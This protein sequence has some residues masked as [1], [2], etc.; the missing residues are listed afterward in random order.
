M[1]NELIHMG[2][3]KGKKWERMFEESRRFYSPEG[4]SPTIPTNA[5]GHHEVKIGELSPRLVGGVG[6]K[7][8]NNGTQYYQQDRIYSSD[9]V[10]MA[11][12]AQI[13]GGSYMYAVEEEIEVFEK[14][15]I[16]ASRGRDPENPSCREREQNL[17]QRLEMG[18]EGMANTLT[19]V[20]KDNL[21]VETVVR[22][23]RL[24]PKECYRL[25]G[26]SDDDF[27]KATAVVSDGQLY[28]QAGNSI[29]VDVLEA[30]FNNLKPYFNTS[31]S[32]DLS[33]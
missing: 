33:V 27:A 20:A 19:T 15:R 16:A 9:T 4:I 31:T 26:F 12:P 21:C 3:L 6:E 23:R 11:H 14:Q 28:R 18:E 17:S 29:V 8:S 25:M 10:A 24:T 5:G 30:I 2:N 7:K 13:P 32:T 1:K 22:V